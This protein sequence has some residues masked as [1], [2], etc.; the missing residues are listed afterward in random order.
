MSSFSLHV[1][2]T[3]FVIKKRLIRAVGF[4][5]VE[6]PMAQIT[7]QTRRHC[8]HKSKHVGSGPWKENL[9]LQNFLEYAAKELASHYDN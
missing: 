4:G 8:P 6:E 2:S 1:A 7:Y 3:S 5:L 9:D